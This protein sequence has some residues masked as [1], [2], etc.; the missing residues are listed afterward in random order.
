MRTSECL[1]IAARQA[2]LSMVCGQVEVSVNA[3]RV[4]INEDRYE[5]RSQHSQTI[6]TIVLVELIGP[7]DGLD[8]HDR[9]VLAKAEASA[10]CADE[11]VSAAR[12]AAARIMG[13]YPF[14]RRVD[15]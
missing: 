8:N 4:L 12:R 3:D 2:V 11:V 13:H 6:G 1:A 7:A 9:R 5:A 14:W 10:W 15:E